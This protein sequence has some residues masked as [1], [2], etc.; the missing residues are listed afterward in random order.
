[1][2]TTH[3]GVIIVVLRQ[4]YNY[5]NE[6][7]SDPFWEFGSFGSTKCHYTNL[8]NPKKAHE[9]EKKR[10]AFAQGGHEGFKLVYLTP[11][12]SIIKHN[13]FIENSS[14]LIRKDF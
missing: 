11:P 9:L 2:D 3:S 5:P 10:F 7:R 6:K 13:G 4:P 1:M 14:S 12:L 8:M